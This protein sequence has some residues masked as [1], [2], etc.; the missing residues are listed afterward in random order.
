[1]DIRNFF[2][3]FLLILGR[4]YV[5]CNSNLTKLQFPFDLP[6]GKG[7]WIQPTIGKGTTLMYSK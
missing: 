7:P 6:K 3:A 2:F 4:F 5:D 1:M